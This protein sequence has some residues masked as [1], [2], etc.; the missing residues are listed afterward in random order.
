MLFIICLLLAGVFSGLLAGLLGVGGGMVLVPVL[1]ALLPE[2]GVPATH[3]TQ[4]AVGTSLACIVLTS[5][6]SARSHYLRGAVIVPVFFRMLPG[7]MLGALC[8][9]AIADYL[10]SAAL[11]QVFAVGTLIVAAKMLID[12]VRPAKQENEGVAED[13]R[14]TLG[15]GGTFIGAASALVGIGGGTFTVP[16]LHWLK[17]PIAKAVGTS[18][19]CGLPI[20]FAGAIGFIALGWIIEELPS[21]M[22]GYVHAY[23]VLCIA[24]TSVIAAPIGAKFAHKLPAKTLKRLFAVMLVIVGLLLFFK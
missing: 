24:S 13:S 2:A 6:S 15:V 18:A 1:I 8:G 3:L 11:R 21:G 9:A 22:L 12:G 14:L 23:S 16:F 19:A 10:S 5:I 7:L 20:A 4:V 17:H